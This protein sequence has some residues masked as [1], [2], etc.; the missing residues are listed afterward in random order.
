MQ[1]RGR[2]GCESRGKVPW[3]GKRADIWA[4]SSRARRDGFNLSDLL[5]VVERRFARK[6][7]G[8]RI[9]IHEWE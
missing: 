4:F 9:M 5:A 3:T 6:G 8:A 2:Q 7:A 1:V